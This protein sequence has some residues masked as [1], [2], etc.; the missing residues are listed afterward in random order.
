MAMISISRR[1][2]GRDT[3]GRPLIR[4][5]PRS[6]MFFPL[7]VLAA[8]LPGLYA[9][10]WWNLT[11]PGPWWGLRGLAVL[12]GWVFD[13]LP[14]VDTLQPAME[15]RAFRSVAFQPPLY[16]WLEAVGLAL[17]SDRTPSAI[18]L[19]SYIAGALVVLLVYWHG[20]LW[21]GSS[22]GLIGALL[23]AF[24]PHLLSQMKEASPA[25]VTLAAT[26]AAMYCYGRHFRVSVGTSHW[27]L[28][29]GG[30][31]WVVGGGLA[32]G[33]AMLSM[34]GVG[35]LCV[36][37]ILLHQA[38]LRSELGSVERLDRPWYGWWNNPSLLAGSIS[39]GLGLLM[40]APW[41]STMWM[42]HGREFLGALLHPPDPL[43]W[44]RPTLLARL[45]DLAPSTLP[46]ALFGVA[47]A[48]KGA[49]VSERDD[50][51]TIGGVFWVVW[52]SVAALAPALWVGGPQST[53]GLFLLI[54]LNLLAA[55][56][57]RDLVVRR[58][59]VRRLSW[60]APA[61]AVSVAWWLSGDL[62]SAVIGLTHGH[63]GPRSALGLHLAL[64]LLVA[65]IWLSKG[66][67]RWARRRDLR[68]RR[69]LASFL[70]VVTVTA[71]ADGL[72][73]VTFRHLETR[74]L[75]NLRSAV[76]LRHRAH[77]F[78]AITVVGPDLDHPRIEGP[79][80]GGRLRFILRSTLPGVPEADLTGTE[81]LLT[82]SEPEGHRLVVLVGPEHR[83]S[84]AVQSQLGLEAIHPSQVGRTGLLDAFATTMAVSRNAAISTSTR[85]K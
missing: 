53:M 8:V 2:E 29:G 38:Y 42:H 47:R 69:V 54:P 11:P 22:V 13:Q 56:A 60:L 39:L 78:E 61:T 14:A 4:P 71:L 55:K 32:L 52:L 84:Y 57:I 63:L 82:S 7:V 30:A 83:L 10:N 65:V 43:G 76:L 70:L 58:A 41:Y 67:D 20:R 75:M 45:N 35:L 59:S 62:R 26:L 77:P 6:A 24:N 12:D 18:V 50:G 16:A 23:T 27:S 34:G 25:T 36:P 68:Q 28:R 46:L 64:D 81:Q 80:P 37:V 44:E 72:R 19:P 51:A 3:L 1:P 40:A 15:A 73:E 66:L 33:L 5:M 74:E 21:R 48:I 49:M 31:W 79:A 17:G 85:T 9:L